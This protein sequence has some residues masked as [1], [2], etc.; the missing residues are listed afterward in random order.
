[1]LDKKTILVVDDDE[2]IN[3]L[4]TNTLSI[5]YRVD[6][7]MCGMTAIAYCSNKIPDAILLDVNLGDIDGREVCSIL[8]QEFGERMP[9]LI[10]ISGDDTEQNVIS[11]FDKG[12]D[13]F[14]PKPFSPE[15]VLGKVE[16]LLKYRA[17]ITN[18]QLQSDELNELVS[19]SMSQ[20]SSYGALLHMVKQLNHCDSE[21]E[22]ADTVFKFLASQGLVSAI[23]FVNNHSS[24][25]FDQK[26]RICSPIVREV[27][28][29]AHNKRRIYKLGNRLLT[30]DQHC[31][32]LIM[33]PPEESAEEYG[34]FI[35][36]AA[37]LI[38]ALE[39]R[40]LG[41]LRERELSQLHDELSALILDLHRSVEDVR[42]RKQRLIDDIV[43]RISLSFHQLEL[44][45]AQE[46]YFSRM[47]EDTVMTHDDNNNV[48]MTLQQQ[49]GR[50][51]QE[52][53][54]LV[55]PAK[56]DSAE[57]GHEDIELF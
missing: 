43:L 54:E 9:P 50:L 7:E 1:M 40:Y 22:I 15:Q 33:N 29:L 13:D 20:A 10:F 47:L 28:E 51:V 55:K 2:A 46:E 3:S 26:S 6:S 39:A 23:Y 17:M 12:A 4:L 48:I 11:C 57:V 45:E 53:N 21:Q 18:L 56:Q 16:A 34:I 27:F 42:V 19:T 41:Y 5:K 35:D 14:I 38:E 52:I 32:L 30:S 31:S 37:V 44:T 36:V 25:C 24:Q 8:R 49:L